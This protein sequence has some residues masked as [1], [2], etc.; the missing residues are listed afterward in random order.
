[1]KITQSQLKKIIAQEIKE[2]FMDRLRGGDKPDPAA[3]KLKLVLDAL[4]DVLEAVQ[5]AEHDAFVEDR[6]NFVRGFIERGLL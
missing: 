1:M 6:I 4:D 5:G 2:G 3:M